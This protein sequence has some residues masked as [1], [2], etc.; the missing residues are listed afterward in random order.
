MGSM[1]SSFTGKVMDKLFSNAGIGFVSIMVGSFAKNLDLGFYSNRGT[2]VN[3]GQP[4]DV[5]YIGPTYT[6]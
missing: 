2:R 3:I 1:N 4:D 5:A 6:T